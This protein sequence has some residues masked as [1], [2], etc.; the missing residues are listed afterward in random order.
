[1]TDDEREKRP[2]SPMKEL[3]DD[4]VAA[5]KET[6]KG[7]RDQQD[8]KLR[9]FVLERCA[10]AFSNL[11]QAMSARTAARAEMLRVEKQR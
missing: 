9:S 6:V 10:Q 2:L 4:L 3:H 5:L 8:L 1:M 11:D 7:A